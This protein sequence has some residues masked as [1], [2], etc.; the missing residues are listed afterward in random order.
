MEYS[1]KNILVLTV[2][3]EGFAL[4]LAFALSW[5][6]RIS[7]FPLTDNIYRDISLGTAG[8]LLPIAFFLY[9]M[10]RHAEKIASLRSLR[11]R[12]RTDIK[13]IFS[14]T[15]LPDLVLISLMAGFSEEMLFR[16]VIQTEFGI[17]I[18]SIVFGLMHAISA[19]YVIVTIVMGIY[20]GAFYYYSGSLLVPV[21]IHFIYDLAALMYLRY[22]IA[23]D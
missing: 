16:G 23:E 1:R 17:F 10:S 12:V 20:I 4:L 13:A 22:C 21:Q 6:F 8:A 14:N 2:V 5:Y 15:G 7:L 18:A 9:A 3:M 11:N 19:A